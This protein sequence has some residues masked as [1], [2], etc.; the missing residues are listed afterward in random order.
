MI[1][2]ETL[3]LVIIIVTMDSGKYPQWML[4]QMG[5][6]LLRNRIL[7]QNAY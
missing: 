5:V 2:L 4:E 3:H 6:S 1:K 7:P